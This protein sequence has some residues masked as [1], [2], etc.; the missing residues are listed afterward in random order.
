MR[1]D[2]FIVAAEELIFQALRDGQFAWMQ[3]FVSCTGDGDD[4]RRFRV[5]DVRR[6]VPFRVHQHRVS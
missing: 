2:F 4:I 5:G 6:R 1:C 3:S